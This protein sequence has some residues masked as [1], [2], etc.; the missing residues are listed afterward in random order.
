MFVNL[1]HYEPLTI[2]FIHGFPSGN[3]NSI[4]FS[5]HFWQ[6]SLYS[7]INTERQH[8]P[9]IFLLASVC[10]DGPAVDVINP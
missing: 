2:P 4:D 9:D 6:Y 5:F 1:R 7:L 8:L 10:C 3:I